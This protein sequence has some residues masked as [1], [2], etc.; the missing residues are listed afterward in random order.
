[1]GPGGV[2]G[3]GL[4]VLLTGLL[5][6][7][8][9]NSEGSF[10]FYVFNQLVLK[11]PGTKA[12]GFKTDITHLG[13]IST[14]RRWGLGYKS[15]TGDPPFLMPNECDSSPFDHQSILMKDHFIINH[16]NNKNSFKY[17]FINFL[18]MGC[19]SQIPRPN[20]KDLF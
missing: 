19:L 11:A 17:H 20:N 15:A 7:T 6:L 16:G 13:E 5:N 14:W 3:W 2:G 1:M 8:W 18:N 4:L 12:G 10:F 9:C